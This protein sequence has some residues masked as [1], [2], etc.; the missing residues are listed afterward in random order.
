M[1]VKKKMG[2]PRGPVKTKLTC[3]VGKE[4]AERLRAKA[5]DEKRKISDQLELVIE[6]Y[7]E[8]TR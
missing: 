1:K 8:G 3:Y 2:R 6:R 4:L 7:L 5:R